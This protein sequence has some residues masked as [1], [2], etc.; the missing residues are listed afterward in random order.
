MDLPRK[1]AI[2]KTNYRQEKERRNRFVLMA[3][4][5]QLFRVDGLTWLTYFVLMA[6]RGQ[7]FDHRQS[8]KMIDRSNRVAYLTLS[9]GTRWGQS[10][11]S[12]LSLQVLE[13]P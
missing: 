9:R 3:S 10:S 5:A 6:S 4:L 7:I 8:N 13:G 11:S 1:E 2:A 12:L